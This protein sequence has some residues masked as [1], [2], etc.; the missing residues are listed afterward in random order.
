MTEEGPEKK[1]RHAIFMDG[2]AQCYLSTSFPNITNFN[3]NPIKISMGISSSG[4]QKPL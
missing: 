4:L 2:N 1:K 3:V